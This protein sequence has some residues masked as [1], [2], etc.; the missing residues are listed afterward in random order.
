MR[1]FARRG[2]TRGT[3]SGCLLR[4]L[5]WTLLRSQ[6]L[7]LRTWARL[8]R[9]FFRCLPGGR[10][11]RWVMLRSRAGG[12]GLDGGRDF[13]CDG[14]AGDWREEAAGGGGGGGF[15]GGGGVGGGVG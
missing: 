3:W 14:L 5:R 2:S 10:R 1:T 12:P 15:L 9:V 6:R 8:L 13:A 11:C 7:F 4:R